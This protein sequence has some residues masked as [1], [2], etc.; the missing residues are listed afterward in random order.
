VLVATLIMVVS[1]VTVTAAMRQ[2]SVNRE[3]LRRY[4]QLY[5]A[6]VSIHDKIMAEALTDNSQAK[7]TL[8]GLEY[9]YACHLEQS[10]NSYVYG[11][12]AAESSNSGPFSIMLFK[13][14]LDVGGKEFE[15]YKTQY[16][17]RLPNG[18]EDDL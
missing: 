6:T 12:D 5:T 8:N 11:E 2:F 3:Q 1:I 10:A 15:F 7:G 9:R 4:E 17:K 14:T 18:K 16:K 13:V